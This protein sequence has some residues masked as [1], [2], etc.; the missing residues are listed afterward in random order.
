[1]QSVLASVSLLVL[2]VNS[3]PI[4]TSDTGHGDQACTDAITTNKMFLDK[5][6]DVSDN[7]KGIDQLRRRSRNSVASK[8]LNSA[9]TSVSHF[10]LPFHMCTSYY[11]V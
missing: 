6:L 1:M 7:S 11:F 4:C 8:L 3:H 5:W 9:F 2:V 10:Y